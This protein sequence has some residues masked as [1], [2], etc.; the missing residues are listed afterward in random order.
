MALDL[1]TSQEL[2]LVPARRA[3]GVT[4]PRVFLATSRRRGGSLM[5]GP[6][7]MLPWIL[8]TAFLFG[9]LTTIWIAAPSAAIARP[10]DIDPGPGESG[11]PTADDQ[12]SPT[13]KPKRVAS[14]IVSRT[15]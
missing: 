2:R 9:L 14:P 7:G 13:P 8:R 11:D 10:Y 3:C 12:P 15:P 4:P 6:R 5:V 1:L